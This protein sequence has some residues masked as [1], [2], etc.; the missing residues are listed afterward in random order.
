MSPFFI[1]AD[2]YFTSLITKKRAG[3][4][5][6]H[7]ITLSEIIAF[8]AHTNHDVLNIIDTGC[9]NLDAEKTKHLSS[10]SKVIWSDL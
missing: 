2:A 1:E 3:Y 7:V 8:F 9:R 5:F 4:D 6:D 10:Y